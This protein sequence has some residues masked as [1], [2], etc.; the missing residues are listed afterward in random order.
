MSDR[1]KEIKTEWLNEEGISEAEYRA[2]LW[3][4]FRYLLQL[5]APTGAVAGDEE[6]GPEPGEGEG[7]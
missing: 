6:E 2:R 7:R 1:V 3:K 5:S 4:V